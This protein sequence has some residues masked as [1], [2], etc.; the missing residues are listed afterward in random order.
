MFDGQHEFEV[1]EA[2]INTNVSVKLAMPQPDPQN[3]GS[4]VFPS[5]ECYLKAS[6]KGSVLILEGATE[7]CLPKSFI[8]CIDRVSTIMYVPAG[9]RLKT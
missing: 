7:R 5:I 2:L 4:I 1:P 3:P 6:L 9:S 8:F